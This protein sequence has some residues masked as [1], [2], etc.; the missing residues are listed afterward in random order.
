MSSLQNLDQERANFAWEK[1]NKVKPHGKDYKNLSK[2]APALVMT[3][4]LMQTLAYYKSRGSEPAD[5]LLEHLQEWL[6]KKGILNA[7]G[8]DFDGVMRGL[9]ACSSADYMR[10]TDETLDILRWIRQFADALF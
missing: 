8:R 10:A 4:G 9:Q 2:G 6:L 1:V 7:E 3:N 5:A